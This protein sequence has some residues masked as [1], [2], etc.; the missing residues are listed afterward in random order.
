MLTSLDL[1]TECGV[2][3]CK[4][5]DCGH[6]L[7]P[8]RC[9]VTR[10]GVYAEPPGITA[11]VSVFRDVDSFGDWL[12][13]RPDVTFVGHHLKYDLKVLAAKGLAIP[14][15]RWED[16]TQL[17]CVASITKPDDH[18]LADYET[19]RKELN[20]TRP[21]G[22]GHRA[23][24][25]NSL[26]VQAPYR[27]GIEP[28]WEPVDHADDDYVL[29]DC[30]YTYK[31]NEWYTRR[32]KQEGTYDFYKKRLLPWG[33]VLL[34][35][36]L[37]GIA[38]DLHAIALASGDALVAA[39]QARRELDDLWAPA[40]EAYR[41]LNAH[42][43]AV[44]YQQM[45]FAA[46]QKMEV[47]TEEKVKRA[48]DR[49]GKMRDAAIAKLPTKMNLDSP[50]QLAWI[51][52]DFYKLDITDF[53]DDETTGKD[54][55]QKLAGSRKDLK[56][57]LEY[58]MQ[59]KLTTSFFPSYRDM[60]VNGVIHCNFNQDIARTGRL[61]SSS[62]NL[63][64]VPGHL[65]SIF[66]ARPG[67]KLIDKDAA[68]IEPNVICFYT[69]DVNL[70]GILSRG[71]DFHGYN[72]KIFFQLDC[73]VKDVK[74]L[75]PRERDMS[76]RVGLSLFYGA[77]KGRLQGTSEEFGYNWSTKYCQQVLTQF[78]DFYSG[79]YFYR[80]QIV[81]PALLQGHL[82]NLMGRSYEIEDPSDIHMKG[83]NTLIQGGASD[84]IVESA[85]RAQDEFDRRGIDAH[86]LLL[87]HDELVV[88]APDEHVALCETI[89]DRCMTDYSLTTSLGPIHL[90]V[91]GKT[92][93]VWE[94]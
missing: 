13:S 17:Q 2:E 32:L 71:E 28:F 4:A 47:Q 74:R 44:K 1:E 89:I 88:E 19:K 5:S 64:Q 26:K 12:S 52:R 15:E 22:R 75:F 39:A 87:V 63:Q 38:I 42:K 27:L 41:E 76:K 49:Y 20:K 34:R 61:S 9:R 86:V 92:S 50:K 59:N 62:P 66:K 73:E 25:R 90:K 8:H 24:K 85:K 81:K 56:I 70:Y 58:R 53:H 37:R 93:G 23:A 11:F 6:A 60:A 30:Y 36:E 65:H 33:K 40:Y 54:V 78:K 68:A 80:D 55:L 3:G 82:T 48:V 46:L 29:R 45:L 77:G 10:I 51:L 31:L 14:L 57:F 16:D 72:T 35:A 84:L 79:V 83:F 91:E 67:Y 43:M 18:Y 7:D 69:E 21:K 94:K